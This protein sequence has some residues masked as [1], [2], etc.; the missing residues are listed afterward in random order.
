MQVAEGDQIVA[1]LWQ[2]SPERLVRDA[3]LDH[4]EQTL[5]GLPDPDFSVSVFATDPLPAGDATE[6]KVQLAEH[7]RQY[8][9]SRWIAFTSKFRLEEMGFAVRLNEP[10]PKH[11]DV[12]L[13]TVLGIQRVEELSAVFNENDRERLI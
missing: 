11:H 1:R 7:V 3:E 9:K 13:G 4:R 5:E 6:Q 10:P 12:V 8:R 2:W